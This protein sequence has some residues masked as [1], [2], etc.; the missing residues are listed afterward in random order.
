MERLT[1]KTYVNKRFDGYCF[2]GINTV[3]DYK[4][5]YGSGY[6]T[7]VLSRAE[8]KLG[9]YED[10]MEENGYDNLNTLKN[11]L[12]HNKGFA[13]ALI[14]EKDELSSQIKVL[15]SENKKLEQQFVELEEFLMKKMSNIDVRI[16]DYAVYKTVYNK[17]LRVKG[18]IHDKVRWGGK[19]IERCL[20]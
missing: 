4:E 13:N 3:K 6:L 7:I 2:N 20:S 17:L 9:E 11:D 1:T 5:A 10:F 15:R 14:T 19:L 18:G 16:C 8:D 12:D